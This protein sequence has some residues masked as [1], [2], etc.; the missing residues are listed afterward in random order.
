[1]SDALTRT[2]EQLVDK[3]LQ[4][5]LAPHLTALTQLNAFLRGGGVVVRRG[6]GRPSVSGGT[7]CAIIGCSR[8]ARSKGYCA[9]HY[10]KFR[11]LTKSNRLPSDWADPAKP[12][13]VKDIVLPR[14]RA[15][16]KG[17]RKS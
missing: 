9:A 3:R 12:Q 11:N 16:H 5:V 15:A 14:G 6:P 7:S 8:P 1:M 17:K 10:Q 4:S 13:S 2:I